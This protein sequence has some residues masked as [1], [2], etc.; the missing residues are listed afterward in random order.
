[1]KR[2]LL[3]LL[4]LVAAP[5]S[6]QRA[7]TDSVAATV[8]AVFAAA[9][10][11]DMDALGRLYDPNVTIG[12]GAGL[13]RGWAS[14]R[15][16]HLAPELR[17]FRNFRYRPFD[18][19][20]RLLGPRTAYALFRYALRADTAERAVDVVGRGTMVLTRMPGGHWH[21]VHSHTSGRARRDTDPAFP[22]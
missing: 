7:L 20:V 17:D 19:E 8:R 5:A 9:E 12:E 16:H 15:D 10:R 22:Q 4:L 11:G 18:V 3:P 14:Y 13:D 21:V 1:M 2:L 6:A